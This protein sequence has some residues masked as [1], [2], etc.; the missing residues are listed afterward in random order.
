MRTG[1]HHQ[2]EN[3]VN[4]FQELYAWNIKGHGKNQTIPSGS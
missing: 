2:D 3:T 1:I 4:V